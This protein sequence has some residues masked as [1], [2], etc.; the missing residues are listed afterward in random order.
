MK[1]KQYQSGSSHLVVVILIVVAV[2]IALGAA[3][4]NKIQ[5]DNYNNELKTV[6]EGE[7]V[8]NDSTDSVSDIKDDSAVIDDI[9]SRDPIAPGGIGLID[10]DQVA[11]DKTA[12]R[13]QGNTSV[14]INYPGDWTQLKEE[15]ATSLVSPDK[16]VSVYMYLDTGV[17]VMQSSCKIGGLGMPKINQISV[18]STVGYPGYRLATYITEASDASAN[19]YYFYRSIL[20]EN[21]PT[22]QAVGVGDSTCDFYGAILIEQDNVATDVP[23]DVSLQLEVRSIVI[24]DATGNPTLEEINEVMKTDYFKIA[25]R[26]IR[27]V[28]IK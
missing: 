22:T 28:S 12:T 6:T 9:E 10:S 15:S 3:L 4:Y 18:E 27:S 16:K 5:S 26:I 17:M 21:T 25:Q 2:F 13:S 20:Q 7:L 19:K 8:N 1:Q 14:S 23:D 11:L 24:D